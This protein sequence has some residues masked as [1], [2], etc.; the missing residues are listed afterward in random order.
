MPDRES[1]RE[2]TR[3]VVDSR[4]LSKRKDELNNKILNLLT[5]CEISLLV[6]ALAGESHKF[7][8]IIKACHVLTCISIGDSILRATSSD[9]SQ[10]PLQ[11]VSVLSSSLPQRIAFNANSPGWH[12]HSIG[13]EL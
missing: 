10:Y 12:S 7:P 5:I 13:P 4:M 3:F 1:G 11:T 9:R 2:R 8:C 6:V